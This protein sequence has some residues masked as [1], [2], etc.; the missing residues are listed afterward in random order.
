[1]QHKAQIMIN[2]TDFD[3]ETFVECLV[4]HYR[5][6]E[7]TEQEKAM[8]DAGIEFREQKNH[9]GLRCWMKDDFAKSKGKT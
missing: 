7:L 4:K 8:V 2:S 3:E 6:E 1:M 5:G 9:Q